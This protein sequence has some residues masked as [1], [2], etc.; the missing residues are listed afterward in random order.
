MQVCAIQDILQLVDW[1]SIIQSESSSFVVLAT[2][3]GNDQYLPDIE[4]EKRIDVCMKTG[5]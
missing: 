3:A 4:I 1:M 2:D 5:T